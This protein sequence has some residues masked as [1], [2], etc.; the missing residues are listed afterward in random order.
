MTGLAVLQQA[1]DL[2]LDGLIVIPGGGEAALAVRAV[3]PLPRHHLTGQ[4]GKGHLIRPLRGHLPLKGKAW[5]GVRQRLVVRADEAPDV[6]AVHR[7]RAAAHHVTGAH[8]AL[9]DGDHAAGHGLHQAHV[10]AAAAVVAPA[11]VLPVVDYRVAGRR[12]EGVVLLPDA[13]LLGQLR[14]P[15]HADLQRRD[16][17]RAGPDPRGGHRG[18]A[19]GVAGQNGVA[20]GQR[21]VVIVGAQDVVVLG[22]AGHGAQ[23]AAHGLHHGGAQCLFSHVRSPFVEPR[24]KSADRRGRL[25]R[26]RH[27]RCVP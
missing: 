13:P 21:T 26:P 9:D 10:V 3:A 17:R 5:G 24:P 2:R 20:A 1:V 16:G 14:H 18:G 11:V 22:A 27:D 19:V 6:P 8:V 15:G 25:R 7:Q 23:P 4:G 12:H